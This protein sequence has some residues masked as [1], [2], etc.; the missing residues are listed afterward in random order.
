MTRW[1][2]F[3]YSICELVYA[4]LRDKAVWRFPCC[5]PYVF[6]SLRCFHSLCDYPFLISVP[7]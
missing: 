1:T 7:I 4:N 3:P 5:A 6:W 2:V